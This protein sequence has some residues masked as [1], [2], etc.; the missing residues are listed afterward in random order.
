MKE[1]TPRDRMEISET[2]L[3]GSEAYDNTIVNGTLRA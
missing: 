1:E 3:V 2:F